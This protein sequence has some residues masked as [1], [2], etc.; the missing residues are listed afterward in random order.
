MVGNDAINY[1]DYLGMNDLNWTTRFPNSLPS[2]VEIG[3]DCD[4]ASEAVDFSYRIWPTSMTANGFVAVVQFNF[5]SDSSDVYL[6]SFRWQTCSRGLND[7]GDGNKVPDGLDP[8]VD[9]IGQRTSSVLRSSD[10]GMSN[11]SDLNVQTEIVAFY[12]VC[13][14]E[15]KKWVEKE[16]SRARGM[17]TRQ[18]AEDEWTWQQNETG[19]N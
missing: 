15:T 4:P 9:D 8:R 6:T 17:F 12:V 13:D 11:P 5:V 7:G 19:K 10:E 1:I 14:C 2:G 3:G 16:G 18:S